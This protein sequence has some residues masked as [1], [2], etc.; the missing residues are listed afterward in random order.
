MTASHPD[1]HATAPR[2]T[3]AGGGP[4]VAILGA[5][6]LVGLEMLRLLDER[7]MPV[8]RL[9]PLASRGGDDRVV[10]FRGEARPVLQASPELLAGADLVLASA[11]GAVSRRLLPDAAAA[12]ALCIDNT[13]AFRM[14]PDCPLVVPEVNGQVL[15]DWPPTPGRGGIIA[16]P[17]CSTIQLLVALAPLHALAGLR[18]VVVSTYQSLSGAGRSALERFRQDSR[19][20]LDRPE[21]GSSLAEDSMALDCRPLIGPA[22]A[23]GHTEEELKMVRETARLLDERVDVDVTCVR[24][25]VERGHAETVW[26]ET[27]RPVTVEAARQALDE[28]PGV[29]VGDAEAVTQRRLAGF[30]DVHVSRLRPVRGARHGLQFWV[31]G[32]NLLKGAALNAVQIAERLQR[33]SV[34][35]GRAAG[36]MGAGR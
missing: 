8:G 5:T 11:G 13:S 16:N 17:N 24:V 10:S 32:D 36:L 28:A 31:V 29:T 19:L 18:R 3:T 34:P 12:G 1:Q 21:E 22:D 15:D 30:H 35:V 33:H 27:E 4:V 25:P 2:S 23:D 9:L 14:D 20:L 26:I 7:G 6:G